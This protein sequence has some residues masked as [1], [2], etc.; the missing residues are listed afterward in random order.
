MIG[1]VLLLVAVACAPAAQQSMFGPT[2]RPA[3]TSGGLL[4]PA[5]RAT[6]T[7]LTDEAQHTIGPARSGDG[8]DGHNPR[9]DLRLHFETS[10]VQV[11]SIGAA[12]PWSVALQL[13][14]YG[15]GDA[16]AVA[17]PAEPRSYGRT[18][19]YQR[20]GLVEMYI[21][22][23]DGL[24]QA[25]TMRAPPAGA[26]E[27]G[28]LRLVVSLS[29][30]PDARVNQD[31]R[32][33][34]W[35]NDDGVEIGRY[36]SLAAWDAEGQALPARLV[37]ACSAAWLEVDDRAATYPVTI[38]PLVQ[39][40][41]VTAGDGLAGDRFGTSVALSAD[42]STAIVGSQ[43]DDVGMNVDQGSAYVFVKSGSTWS[44]QTM[45]TASD[46]A[47]GDSFGDSVALSTDGSTALV[48]ASVHTV[49]SNPLQGAAYVYMRSGTIWTQQQILTAG[50]GAVADN[51]GLSVALSGNG[52]TA[53]VGAYLDRRD[54]QHG[55][56][57]RIRVHQERVRLEPAAE[58]DRDTRRPER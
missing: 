51:F 23:H 47:A 27:D 50:D 1:C 38:D 35:L 55:S 33:L 14:S 25:F 57:L 29:G 31:E 58:A 42:G 5:D 21:N 41:Q 30:L 43:S 34:T 45:L 32:G 16:Q 28:P 7:V 53:I 26:R 22:E 6:L 3:A 11:R 48:G 52:N 15:R 20:P 46:G 40:A 13:A 8:L 24:E 37:L 56:G 19:E 2:A 9:H 44:Q 39:Q 12:H 18:V 4:A 17:E 49:G 10:G 54:R 36:G